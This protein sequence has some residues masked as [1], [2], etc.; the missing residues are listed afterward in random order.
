MTSSPLVGGL[1]PVA[2]AVAPN[3]GRRTKRNHPGLPVTLPELVR[4]AAEC[5]EAGAAMIHV[6]IR[7]AQERHLL[8]AD[9]Y[10]DVIHAI[11][12][13]IGD[14]LV[15]QITSESVGLYAPEAQMAVVKAVRPEAVSLALREL[16]PDPAHER[17]FTA[18]LQWLRQE[19]IVPQVILYSPEEVFRF[20]GMRQRGLIPWNSIPVLFVLGSYA[21]DRASVP[22]D[23]LAF[24]AAGMPRFDHWMVCAFGR[25]EAA[26]VT[27]AAL[28]GGHVR[29][30]F[31]NNFHQPDGSL[32]PDNATQVRTVAQGLQKTGCPLA[33]AARLRATWAT[34]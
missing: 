32:A 12:T 1:P 6:H 7:D 20:A 16:V 10:R 27:A 28:L 14:R 23:L 22:A 3:G 2:I 17:G 8:D 4:T 29:V 33:D 15:I 26:C 13:A 9:I 5:G 11:R 24:L 21:G 19:Y 30:G 31:E 25:H 34:F 18:F